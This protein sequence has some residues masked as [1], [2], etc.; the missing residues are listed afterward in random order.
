MNLFVIGISVGIEL[1]C[2]HSCR[3][4]EEDK[5]GAEVGQRWGRGVAEALGRGGPVQRGI[6]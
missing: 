6:Q 2:Q 3:L 5:G 4:A 1:R